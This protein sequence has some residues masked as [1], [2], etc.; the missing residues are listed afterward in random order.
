M[1][2]YKKDT[3]FGVVAGLPYVKTSKFDCNR[4]LCYWINNLSLSR[5]LKLNN[6][7]RAYIIDNFIRIFY[8]FDFYDKNY[9][10]NIVKKNSEE[11]LFIGDHTFQFRLIFVQYCNATSKTLH[12]NYLVLRWMRI[13]S[14][15]EVN[16]PSYQLTVKI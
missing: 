7:V 12:V 1:K 9:F 6:K 16:A 14:G 3:D 11:I 4:Q 13:R 15:V 10:R 2:T 5:T 8:F